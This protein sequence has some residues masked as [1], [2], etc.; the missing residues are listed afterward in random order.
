MKLI[1]TIALFFLTSSSFGQALVNEPEMQT[2]NFPPINEVSTSEIGNTIVTASLKSVYNDG[3][4]LTSPVSWNSMG[5]HYDMSSGDFYLLTSNNKGKLYVSVEKCV[6]WY[7]NLIKS[8][9]NETYGSIFV[10][11][12]GDKVR[13]GTY[14]FHPDLVM[15]QPIGWL[16]TTNNIQEDLA[17]KKT[18]TIASDK[19]FNQQFIYGGKVGS[20]LKFTY[21]EF[22]DDLSRPS[23]T[24][25]VQYD[26]NDGNTIGF[27]GL[28]VEVVEV[29]NLKITYKVINHFNR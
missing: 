8:N 14:A 22:I 5:G 7:D 11:N 19:S 21:R 25:D 13:F 3:F 17:N 15:G 26:L 27:K 28:K 12:K 20:N 29:D 10:F 2:L 16:K 1:Y 24:Q 9:K 18:I 6:S 4:H 23:F